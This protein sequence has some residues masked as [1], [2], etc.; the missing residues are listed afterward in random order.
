MEDAQL[1]PPRYILPLGLLDKGQSFKIHSLWPLKFL[2][3]GTG[4]KE[5]GVRIPGWSPQYWF[6]HFGTIL[7]I[8]PK[9]QIGSKDLDPT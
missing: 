4:E 3:L 5:S 2:R 1:S 6:A 9:I 7:H 8:H